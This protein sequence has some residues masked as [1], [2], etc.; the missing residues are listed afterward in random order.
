MQFVMGS[1]SN[2]ESAR[3]RSVQNA[4]IR[5]CIWRF[6]ITVQASGPPRRRRRRDL[7]WLTRLGKLAD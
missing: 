7:V 1:L 5:V 2:V 6:R 4:S 3:S